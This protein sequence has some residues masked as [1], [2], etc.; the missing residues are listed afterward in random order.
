[1]TTVADDDNTCDWAADCTGE[2]QERAVRDSGYSGVVMM[3]AVAEG[4]G[5]RRWQRQTMTAADYNGMQDWVADYEGDGQ[6]RVA[7]DGGDTEW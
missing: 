7:R 5:G 2:G 3:S 6:E 1:M 4:G